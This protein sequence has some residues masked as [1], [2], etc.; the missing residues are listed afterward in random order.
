[1]FRLIVAAP[2]ALL[3][4]GGLFTFMAWMVDDGNRQLP[5]AKESLAFNMVMVEQEREAQRRQRTVPEKPETP[6]P[7]PQ[8]VPKSAQASAVTPLV[9]P[10]MPSIAMDASVKGLA[11]SLPAV[12]DVGRDQQ[13]MPLY[14][15]EPK[16]PARALKRN[17]E[18]YVVLSFTIDPQG[19][20]TDIKIVDAQPNR[21]FDREA[22]R[23]LKNWKYQPK[24]EGGKALSQHGQQV[25]VEFNLSK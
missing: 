3:I 24:I 23:A 17:I 10:T 25:K 8:A 18:G 13:A 22:I 7:P 20:P 5:E 16:Y 19:R 9:S 4:T 6:E 21:V 15:V 14:R 1:M 2:L 12:S 11:I